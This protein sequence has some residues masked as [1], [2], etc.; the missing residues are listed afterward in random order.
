MR[1]A[2]VL[3]ITAAVTLGGCSSDWHDATGHSRGSFLAKMDESRCLKD[4]QMPKM[5]AISE[6]IDDALWR[7][8]TCMVRRGWANDSVASRHSN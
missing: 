8:R 7:Y 5:P 3:V 2:P 6:D 4:A 1:I